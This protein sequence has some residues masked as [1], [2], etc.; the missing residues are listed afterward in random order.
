MMDKGIPRHDYKIFNS[1]NEE[2]GIVTSGT[3]S[4]TL[5]KGIGLGYVMFDNAT[6]GN[7]IFISVRN[8][9]IP[10]KVV[11][12]PFINQ[13]IKEKNEPINRTL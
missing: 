10:A 2:I 8:V 4:P 12:L 11:K 7:E 6:T 9:L 3:Q 13:S 5:K 1:R